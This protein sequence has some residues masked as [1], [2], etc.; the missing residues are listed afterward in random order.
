MQTTSQIMMHGYAYLPLLTDIASHLKVPEIKLLASVS[1]LWR[2]VARQALLTKVASASDF[3]EQSIIAQIKRE[4]NAFINEGRP[5]KLALDLAEIYTKYNP[6]W[7]SRSLTHQNC[8]S[9]AFYALTSIL[10]KKIGH[11]QCFAMLLGIKNSFQQTRSLLSFCHQARENKQLAVKHIKEWADNLRNH[12]H[13]YE[14]PILIKELCEIL[15]QGAFTYAIPLFLHEQ[16]STTNWQSLFSS[17]IKI[18]KPAQS[19]EGKYQLSLIRRL[20][21]YLYE[22][23]KSDQ[24]LDKKAKV[25]SFF[26]SIPQKAFRAQLAHSLCNR[27]YSTA[28]NSEGIANEWEI[29]AELAEN[30]NIGYTL[31]AC[32]Q[33]CCEYWLR[34]HPEKLLE[35]LAQRHL[36][37]HKFHLTLIDLLNEFPHFIAQ[38]THTI[39]IINLTTEIKLAIYQE[40]IGMLLHYDQLGTAI[41]VISVQPNDFISSQLK[42]QVESYCNDLGIHEI[43]YTYPMDIEDSTTKTISFNSDSD[44]SI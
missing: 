27:F 15:L 28:F 6:H 36:G 35:I 14:H 33:T 41:K 32:T 16:T 20:S 21:L 9:R 30:I 8:S 40:L 38:C 12:I 2:K 7:I 18:S 3:H 11:E 13:K 19:V 4:T 1:E 25:L 37:V 39:P 34:H 26:N 5:L 22:A 24:I 43:D 44:L 17:I 42:A 23:L 29:T 31:N 10:Y